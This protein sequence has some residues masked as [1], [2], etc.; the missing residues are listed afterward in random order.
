MRSRVQRSLGMVCLLFLLLGCD[1]F[2]R[3]TIED[4]GVIQFPTT[5]EDLDFWDAITHQSIVTND[6]ALHGLLLLS[7][8]DDPCDSYECR[9]EAAASKGWFKGSW[10]GMPEA[11]QSAKVGWMAVAGCQI[12]HIKGGLTM[13]LFG[14]SPRYCSREL[15][16]MGLLPALSE[17]EALTGLEFTAYIDNIED[18]Q[19]LDAAVKAR[20]HLQMLEKEHKRQAEARRISEVLT[21]M[22]PQRIG[23]TEQV[24]QD[25]P[26]PEENAPKT[27]PES[28]SGTA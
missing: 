28:D 1:I 14:D 21:P 9:Y 27:T 20:Q 26:S 22:N 10:G 2:E 3:T 15:S 16:F 4:S 19:R 12:L 8:G 24:P 5:D 6:D 18:R 7:D 17:N 11:D 25:Q 13:Q 23:G